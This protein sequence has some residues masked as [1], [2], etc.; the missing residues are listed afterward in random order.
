MGVRLLV[1][2]DL[3]LGAELPDWGGLGESRRGE[4]EAALRHTVA[5]AVDPA[6][7]V[8]ALLI[9]GDLLDRP[10]PSLDLAAV[11]HRELSAVLEAGIPVVVV[12]GDFDPLDPVTLEY[13][14][15]CL[16]DGVIV[17][18]SPEI[19]RREIPL[20]EGTL[21]VYAAARLPGRTPSDPWAGLVRSDHPGV[22]VG[23]FHAAIVGPETQSHPPLAL[24]LPEERVAASGLNLVVAGRHHSFSART[25]GATAA[26]VPGSTVGLNAREPG[27]RGPILVTFSEDGI[28]VKRETLP[29]R[30]VVEIALAVEGAESEEPILK[31]ILRQRNAAML[32]VRIEG[33]VRRP[34]DLDRATALLAERGL[35][36]DWVD[37]TELVPWDDR[38]ESAVPPDPVFELFVSTLRRRI[39]EAGGE[40]ER[41]HLRHAL[42]AG[43]AAWRER[44]GFHAA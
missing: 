10:E 4:L 43:A 41:A 36:A 40:D 29:L 17:A 33:T 44:E 13:G 2:S 39:A 31:R 30:E 12:P 24:A 8:D 37:D 11:I 19:T 32:R 16:P 27:P 5:M 1:I 25:L 23:L 26:V 35:A 34:L 18:T 14:N 28:A 21:H 20:R 6:R 7:G 42:R 15:G 3:H 9:A 22:H 38:D